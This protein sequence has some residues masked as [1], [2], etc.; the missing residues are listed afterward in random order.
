MRFQVATL[1]PSFALSVASDDL[2][3]PAGRVVGFHHTCMGTSVFQVDAVLLPC[4]NSAN[5]LAVKSSASANSSVGSAAD[6]IGTTGGSGSKL[7]N[8]TINMLKSG[9]SSQ[10]AAWSGLAGLA[11]VLLAAVLGLALA[12]LV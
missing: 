7:G 1:G 6:S 12:A 10:R 9:N 2:K 11:H 3:R 8:I 4:D 5:L